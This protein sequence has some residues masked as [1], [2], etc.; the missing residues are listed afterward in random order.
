MFRVLGHISLKRVLESYWDEQGVADKPRATVRTLGENLLQKLFSNTLPTCPSQGLLKDK[1][2]ASSVEVKLP[3]LDH[4]LL[5]RRHQSLRGWRRRQQRRRTG[6]SGARGGGAVGALR[7]GD[8][9][10][11]NR[12]L[13]WTP[14]HQRERELHKVVV[15][16]FRGK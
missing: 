14:H 16:L 5:Q 13:H 6:P 15:E 11:L 10:F 1:L 8:I 2:Y 9:H 3:P 12:I 4:P 7:L